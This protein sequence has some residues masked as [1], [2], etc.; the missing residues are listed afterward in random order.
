MQEL[1]QSHKEQVS[2]F[3]VDTFS[4]GDWCAGIKTES[5]MEQVSPFRVDTF[6]EGDWCAGI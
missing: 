4:R 3:R 1:T 2:S 5:H 6:S